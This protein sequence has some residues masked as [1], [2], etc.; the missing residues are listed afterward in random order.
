MER[1]YQGR[2]GKTYVINEPAMASGGEGSI[3][4]IQGY[5]KLVLKVFKQD[6]RTN[7]REEKLIK[8]VQ[9]QL[10][11]EQLKQ[12]AWPQDIVYDETG[13]VGYVMPRL[14]EN[15]NLNVVYSGQSNKLDLRHRMLIAYNLCAAV[16]TVHS[17][18][19]VCGDLNPQN[20]CVNLN[21]ESE[22]ALQVTLVDT[23]SYHIADGDKTYRCE[24]GLANYLAP[25][26]Q[27]KM[28]KGQDLRRAA[29]PTYTRE[30]DLFAIAVYVF[31]LLM[32]GCH[33]FAC[34]KQASNGY[35][36]TMGAMDDTEQES[37]VLPQPIENIRDGF[38]PFRQKRKGVT[39]PLY[40]PDFA[41]LPVDIQNLFARAFIDGYYDPTKRPSAEEWIGVLKKC[42]S[43]LHYER[44]VKGHYYLKDNSLTCPYC[45]AHVRMMKMMAGEGMGVPRKEETIDTKQ[46]SKD[47][48]G[49]YSSLNTKQTT[50][51][52]QTV[53]RQRQQSTTSN[54]VASGDVTNKLYES[55][56]N[57]K[58]LL[59]LK[60][61]TTIQLIMF[62]FFLLFS[63]YQD[64]Y[65]DENSS[66]I[67][68][69][70]FMK[71]PTV[72]IIG[73]LLGMLVVVV[74]EI[75]KS[76]LRKTVYICVDKRV[77]ALNII[78]CI[79][80]GVMVCYGAAFIDFIAFNYAISIACWDLGFPIAWYVLLGVLF[81]IVSIC[82]NVIGHKELKELHK[83]GMCKTYDTTLKKTVELS[84]LQAM[85]LL[86][87]A[88][89]I[90]CILVAIELN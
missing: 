83:V 34:A 66:L 68:S 69:Y 4:S 20:I 5:E 23:D 60:L 17:L 70:S 26:I 33:P 48:K 36:N 11:E 84:V 40:A 41:S 8:M 9:Y 75:L 55:K 54:T 59:K 51:Q 13:F 73:W 78:N 50:N 25:E 67:M 16:D 46:T 3:Y 1:I 45:E 80:G 49:N 27:K 85:L 71:E 28:E 56:E 21:L 52:Q 47:N 63:F 74:L 37:V 39:Y 32:N 6:R 81:D 77:F 29:L 57:L 88:M 64:F 31:A 58:K 86:F 87:G 90:I 62:D 24:V 44:C 10:N 22:S 76:E 79:L 15:R 65:L 61:A 35:E 42:Q 2:S 19:Q 72:L 14:E 18:G 43:P 12:I 7:A 53:N 82:K 89:T 30:T 38:F